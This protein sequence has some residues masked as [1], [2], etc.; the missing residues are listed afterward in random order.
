[1]EML[2]YSSLL[3]KHGRY[4]E[5]YH[6]YHC[7]HYCC[8]FL[9]TRREHHQHH[10]HH[11]HHLCC[12]SHP[13]LRSTTVQHPLHPQQSCCGSYCVCLFSFCCCCRWILVCGAFVWNWCSL[14]LW[15]LLLL[16]LLLLL[17]GNTKKVSLASTYT[18][19]VLRLRGSNLPGAAAHRVLLK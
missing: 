7:C 6:F 3:G 8:C 12:W 2:L 17:V 15:L 16:L 14:H 1:M 19:T 18:T 10:Q 5:C 9:S 11:R 13:S 4:H